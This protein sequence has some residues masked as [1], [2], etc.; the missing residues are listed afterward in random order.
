MF[1]RVTVYVRDTQ[2]CLPGYGA[3]IGGE[4]PWP[5]FELATA[6]SEHPPTEGLHIAFRAPNRAA[7]AD[8]WQAAVLAGFTDDGEPGPRSVY[9]PG[10]HGGFVLD[11]AGNSVESVHH[12]ANGLEGRI[13]H[14]WLR[15]PDIN[16][17]RARF[18]ALADRNGFQIT[19]DEPGWV[20]FASQSGSVSLRRDGQPETKN[21]KITL[22]G[23]SVVEI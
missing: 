21:L 12:E 1:E 6:T 23:G 19:K 20:M 13:D 8:R 15:V 10:Y 9:S 11:P 7:I 5:D 16:E 18:A 17:A 3:I 14:I 2:E 4:G 22:S